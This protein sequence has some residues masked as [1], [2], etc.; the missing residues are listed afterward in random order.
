M[1][2][3]LNQSHDNR[4]STPGKSSNARTR[5]QIQRTSLMHVKAM[6]EERTNAASDLTATA[7]HFGPKKKK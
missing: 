4:R 6:M 3:A 2:K 1:H 5:M 7:M